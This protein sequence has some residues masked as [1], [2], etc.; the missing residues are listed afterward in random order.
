MENLN[1][2]TGSNKIQEVGVCSNDAF[3]REDEAEAN[4]GSYF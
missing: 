1:E 3:S 4:R 2:R